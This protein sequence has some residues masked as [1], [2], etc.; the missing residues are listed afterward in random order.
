MRRKLASNVS[1]VL[2]VTRLQPGG[3]DCGQLPP[4]FQGG[5]PV[6][7]L[8]HPLL[9]GLSAKKSRQNQQQI[10]KQLD[11]IFWKGLPDVLKR[12]LEVKEAANLVQSPP[13]SPSEVLH[14]L[15]PHKVS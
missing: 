6:L 7:V 4:G 2:C 3:V 8:S 13:T 12:S 9:V 14:Q 10:R 11:K 1:S 5:L 15:D